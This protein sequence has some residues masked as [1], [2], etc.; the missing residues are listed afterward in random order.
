[1]TAVARPQQQYQQFPASQSARPT[2]SQATAIEQQRAIAEVQAAVVVAQ[3]CP[4]DIGRAEADM[5]D[6]C[7]RTAM[8]E[9][10]FYAVDNR[11][12]GPSVHLMRELA[13]IWGNVQF[14]VN[15]LARNDDKGESEV[16]AWA[17]DVQTNTRSSRT[18][19]VPHQRMKRGA[20]VD[21]TD[22]QDIY[23]NNQNIGAR[24]VRECIA[25]VLP[26]W[27]TETAQ[28]VCRQTLEVGDGEPLVE[29][30]NNM[31]NGFDAIGISV[32]QMEARLGKPRDKWNAG[33]IAQ[34]KI[35]YTSITRDG[36]DKD[37]LFPAA[38][39]AVSSAADILAG[40]A[41]AVE[42]PKQ[43]R[44]SR[45]K[46]KP[47]ATKAEQQQP[48]PEQ[49]AAEAEQAPAE[50]PQSTPEAIADPA[51]AEPEAATE[52]VAPQEKAKKPKS[53]LRT[54]LE[55]RLFALFKDS[56]VTE[57][58]DRL[59]IYRFIV[60]REDIQSTDDLTD[61]EGT[62]VGDQL[63]RWQQKD[64]LDQRITDILNSATLAMESAQQQH[65]SQQ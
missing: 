10:A 3:N 38:T 54:A 65:D 21:L 36:Y 61:V 47:A 37:E 24:A 52:P 43:Q 33:D 17:W 32:K 40:D 29:R 57:R 64:E 15:E 9:Q 25:T 41:P 11:G 30:I 51:P 44:Q 7:G 26:R 56:E 50:A 6:S 46:Q 5:Y 1:M 4:R 12:T 63:Y 28:D 22:L 62:K 48:K 53:Q 35:A 55:R 14:G 16:Q 34:M 2:I 45:A 18:F 20:R 19:I 58:E 23:L 8:A 13:R 59:I 49:S 39:G 31:V 60:G 42:Q 27:F